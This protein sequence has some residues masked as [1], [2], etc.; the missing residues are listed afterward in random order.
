MKRVVIE[1]YIRLKIGK[2]L[3]GIISEIVKGYRVI[4]APTEREAIE[5]IYKN[6]SKSFKKKMMSFEV[7]KTYSEQVCSY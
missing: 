1:F 4:E 5:I 7:S 2:D 6:L 3:N